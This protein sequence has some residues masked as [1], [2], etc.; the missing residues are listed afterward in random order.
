MTV[1]NEVLKEEEAQE[2]KEFSGSIF[3]CI[4]ALQHLAHFVELIPGEGVLRDFVEYVLTVLRRVLRLSEGV[5]RA[6]SMK[7][8][9]LSNCVELYG[10]VSNLV[11][12]NKGIISLPPDEQSVEFKPT[13]HQRQWTQ[14]HHSHVPE[15]RIV[16]SPS[17]QK[18]VEKESP[19]LDVS[20]VTTTVKE[21]SPTSGDTP[22]NTPV[23]DDEEKGS[24]DEKE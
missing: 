18:T 3:N 2:T 23:C 20:T 22:K 1:L 4:L 21:D 16:S 8:V 10:A 5:S 6:D 13:M 9:V 7:T 14:M 19:I 15:V 12:Q 11:K 17:A 24:F